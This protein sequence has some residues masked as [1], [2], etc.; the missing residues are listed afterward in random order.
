M[1]EHRRSFYPRLV[2]CTNCYSGLNFQRSFIDKPELLR[3]DTKGAPAISTTITVLYSSRTLFGTCCP[4]HR[5]SPTRVPN[6][7]RQD[8]GC[9]DS[10]Q[11]RLKAAPVLF[12]S[13]DRSASRQSDRQDISHQ[14]SW[15]LARANTGSASNWKIIEKLTRA[16][17]DFLAYALTV[18]SD[19][20]EQ[21]HE[22]EVHV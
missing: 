2:G 21:R 19:V 15:R 14:P 10:R 17:M 1:R 18:R 20:I 8:Q 4:N 22:S 13:H 16:G 7:K 12:T 3:A 5:K 6:A 9:D 11:S